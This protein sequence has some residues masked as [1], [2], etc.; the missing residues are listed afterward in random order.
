VD[1]LLG[2]WELGGII[3]FQSG[4]PFTVGMSGDVAN[5]GTGYQRPDRIA[6]GKIS[7]PTVDLWFDASAFAAPSLYTFGNSGRNILRTDTLKNWDF[8]L[9]KNFALHESVALQLRGE[10]FNVLN[11][12]VFGTPDTD[13]TSNTFGRVFSQANSPRVGQVALKLIF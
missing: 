3:A 7:N 10:F 13:L 12:P 9:L 11:H 1:L 2:G 4:D 5:V 6:S 8:S